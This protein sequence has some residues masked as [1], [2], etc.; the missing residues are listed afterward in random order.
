MTLALRPTA[1]AFMAILSVTLLVGNPAYA[2]KKASA[3]PPPAAC[4]DFYGHVNT[5]W[6]RSNPLPPGFASRSRWDELNEL[7]E[8][9]RNDLFIAPLNGAGPA[10][11][12]LN[13][14]MRSADENR[15][16]ADSDRVLQPLLANIEKIRK[17]KDISNVIADMQGRGL[18]V[19]YDY[20]REQENLFSANAI[21][22]PDLGFYT[23]KNPEIIA[24]QSRYRSYVESQLKT[25]GISGEKAGVQSG[26]VLA[27][28]LQLAAVSGNSPSQVLGLKDA[29]K[30]YANLFFSDFLRAQKASGDKITLA[31]PVFF[32][33]LNGLMN[34]KM[35]EHWKS[36]LRFHVINQLAPYLNEAYFSAHSQF[37]EVYLAGNANPDSRK[38]KLRDLIEA[39]APELVDAA[40]AERYIAA[41]HR[42]RARAVSNAIVQTAKLAAGRNANNTSDLNTLNTLK[43]II[44]RDVKNM[45]SMEIGD[46]LATSA[47]MLLRREQF[48]KKVA[49]DWPE[50]FRDSI[51]VLVYLPNKNSI[52]ISHALLQAP[53]L[54]ADAGAQ[55]FGAFGA[56]FAQQISLALSPTTANNTTQRAAIIS[57][58]NAYSLSGSKKV[59]G[60][61]T[62]TQNLADLSGLDLA[63]QS[64]MTSG[65]PDKKA[66]QDFFKAWANMLARVDRDSAL[67]A[68]HSKAIRAPAKW[69]VNGPIANMPA[70]AT[71][72]A[73]KPGAMQRASK[74][75]LKLW[76]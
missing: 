75:Q 17:P 50:N 36:Y 39:S 28:E 64:F 24:A 32:K 46:N 55:N 76:P 42:E 20:Q 74:D 54:D 53:I 14:L 44:G 30:Q 33:T 18:S 6:S 51:P 45:A 35:I 3:P 22:F 16:Q 5:A 23:E 61:M 58:Y 25:S 59:N 63:F 12:K 49:S 21:G 56:L 10:Q 7:S 48:S 31:Q 60:A 38:Q 73:C 40:Y 15:L 72:F 34:P 19:I 65:A 57:Q 29:S 67:L 52:L 43:V 13:A 66:Q 71:A 4:S 41:S 37:Y 11:D 8:R 1:T 47:I 69:R 2:K 62:S 68:S 26:H 9:Q 27:I 70:F